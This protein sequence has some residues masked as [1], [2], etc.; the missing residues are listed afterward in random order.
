[1]AATILA[2]PGKL[3][4]TSHRTPLRPS[5]SA[6]EA[7]FIRPRVGLNLRSRSADGPCDPVSTPHPSATEPSTTE[8]SVAL[9]AQVDLAV[10]QVDREI[11]HYT[12]RLRLLRLMIQKHSS[13]KTSPPSPTE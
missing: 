9:A 4:N 3:F 5:P 2:F 11:A 10:A 12:A 6:A 8:P 1:M 7:A 13:P